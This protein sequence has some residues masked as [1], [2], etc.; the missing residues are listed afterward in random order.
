MTDQPY[1]GVPPALPSAFSKPR[2]KAN[3]FLIVCGLFAAFVFLA[4]IGAVSE[5]GHTARSARLEKEGLDVIPVAISQSALDQFTEVATAGD[6][7]AKER[8]V[9][10]GLVFRVPSGTTVD[11]LS[12]GFA[13]TRCRISEGSHAGEVVYAYAEWVR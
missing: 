6:N 11:I 7:I 13:S 5:G 4:I 1:K 2:R 8:L 12:G 3:W 10:A 9:A